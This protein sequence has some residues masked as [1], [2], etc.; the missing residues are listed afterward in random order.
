MAIL[1]NKGDGDEVDDKIMT[2]WIWKT[3]SVKHLAW[4]SDQWQKWLTSHIQFRMRNSMTYDRHT[5]FLNGRHKR[6]PG[7]HNKNAPKSACSIVR[8]GHTHS[9]VLYLIVVHHLFI[10]IITLEKN[11]WLERC[12][13]LR[14]QIDHSCRSKC[15]MAMSKMNYGP[16]QSVVWAPQSVK[17]DIDEMNNYKYRWMPYLPPSRECCPSW[18]CLGQC[19]AA[20]RFIRILK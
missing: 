13:S 20:Q 9:E 14:H 2:K 11:K 1:L 8:R 18:Q 5:H 4:K 16:S 12:S 10:A 3:Y 15:P 17:R 7:F 19:L 6:C